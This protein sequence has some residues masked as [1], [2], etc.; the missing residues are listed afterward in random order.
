MSP[1][2]SI[3]LIHQDLAEE[4]SWGLP[5]LYD[6]WAKDQRIKPFMVVWPS[7]T[8]KF[9]GQVVNDA[10]PFQLPEDPGARKEAV[11]TYAKRASAWALLVVEQ[12]T[13]S[14]VVIFESPVGTKS[15]HLPISRHGDVKILGDP[16]EFTN[17]DYIGVRC[18]STTLGPWSADPSHQAS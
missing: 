4:A 3:D 11:A 9:E 2:D 12:R 17:V 10:V 7:K 14:V 15:W 6:N 16:K 13:E 18:R 1:T 8:I 5:A